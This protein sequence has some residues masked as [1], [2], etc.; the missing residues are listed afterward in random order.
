MARFG[1]DPRPGGRLDAPLELRQVGARL[2]VPPPCRR[3]LLDAPLELA[4]LGLD[5]A[6]D[7]ACARRQLELHLEVAYGMSFERFLGHVRRQPAGVLQDEAN[8]ERAL[9]Q[10]LDV[11]RAHLATRRDHA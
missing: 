1:A 9:P 10:L 4:P 6:A 2:V 7:E 3:A 8:E 5:L 11:E